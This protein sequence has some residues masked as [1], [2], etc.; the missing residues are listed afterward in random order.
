MKNVL[1]A[2]SQ[3]SEGLL[4]EIYD[5][6]AEHGWQIERCGR[7]LPP[8]WGGDGVVTDYLGVEEL[9]GIRNFETTPVVARGR[10]R[11]ENIRTVACDVPLLAKMVADYFRNK[12]FTRFAAADAREWGG[13]EIDPVAALAEELAKHGLPLERCYWNPHLRSDELTDYRTVVTKLAA[14]FRELPKPAALLVP[15]GMYLAMVY[16]ALDGEGIKVPEEIALLCNTDNATATDKASTPTTRISGELREVGRKMAELLQRMME[17]ETVPHE[18]IQVTPAAIVSRRS[19]DVLAVPDV[20]LATAVS[21]LLC[22]YMNL[23]SIEDAAQAAGISG[24]M[25][26]RLFRRHLGK[27]AVTFLQELRLNRIRDLLDGTELTLSEIARQT[28][29][30]S[31]MSLSLAFKREVGMTPGLYRLSRRK[32]SSH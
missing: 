30:G 15:N 32:H 20:K 26:A 17:G 8:G 19:T 4:G 11:G 25:L 7:Q 28:G 21:F 3:P 22:N 31:D 18:V 1:C 23:I 10:L 12:G 24:S 2:M 14:F 9:R 29:Y 27:T 13:P 16:R 5:F 6:G